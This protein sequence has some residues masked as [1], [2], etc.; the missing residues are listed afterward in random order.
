MCVAVPRSVSIATQV[1][2]R[3]ILI[4]VPSLLVSNSYAL[5]AAH[6]LTGLKTTD[7]KL[8][9]GEHDVSTAAETNSTVV[10]DISQLIIHENYNSGTAQNDIALV[11]LTQPIK[12]NENVGPVCLPWKFQGNTLED[13]PVTVAGWGTTEFSGPKSKTLQKVDLRT[14]S[15]ARCKAD[16]VNANENT[17]CTF[18]TDKD[19][20]QVSGNGIS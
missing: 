7:I 10:H 16:N 15:M 8:V 19:S 1:H 11:R 3:I 2:P 5:T 18:A 9:V 12:Y 13:K 6:C 20:C 17:I 4:E 14:T